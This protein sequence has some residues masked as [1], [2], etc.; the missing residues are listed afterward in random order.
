[1]AAGIGGSVDSGNNIEGDVVVG[2]KGT[3]V[4]NNGTVYAQGGH[5]SYNRDPRN[6][7]GGQEL[8][9]ERTAAWIRLRSMVAM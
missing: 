5:G 2:G 4:I 1:M 6:V 9:V 8:A 7:Y 3:I